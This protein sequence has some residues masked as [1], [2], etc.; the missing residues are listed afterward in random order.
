MKI[1]TY[2]INLKTRT[3]RKVHIINEFAERSEF[4]INMVEACEHK[5]GAIGL[6][7]TIRQIVQKADD[8][9]EEY[10]LICE[11]DHQF[12][13]AYSSQLL[14]NCIGEAKEKDAS[15]LA[16]GVHWYQDIVRVSEQLFWAARFTGTQFIIIFKKFFMPILDADFCE[17]DAADLKM[18]DLTN[19]VFFIYPFISVQRDFGYSDATEANNVQGR[20]AEMFRS[21][22]KNIQIMIDVAAFY[23]NKGI[24]SKFEQENYNDVKIPTYVINLQERMERKAHIEKQFAGRDEFAVAIVDACKRNIAAVGLW[25]S[26]RK[27]IKMAVAHDHDVIIIC[28]DDHEFTQFY[29]REILLKNIF[30]SHRQGADYINAGISYFDFAVPIAENRYW[31]NHCLAGQFLIVYGR[32][33]K[34][35]L[36]ASFDDNVIADM[37]LSTLTVNMMFLYPSISIQRDFGYSDVTPLHHN[38]KGWL[39]DMFKKANFRMKQIQKVH[40]KYHY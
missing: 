39:G 8:S 21:C 34:K 12:T 5:C 28:E 36:E 38:N 4:D 22:S 20:M 35:M 23:K 14:F 3:D 13:L 10:V 2:I 26:I 15:L 29:S 1:P 31:M 19:E 40:Q 30:D 32:F 11:D 6:W 25:E 17:S 33:Y 16:G 7:N 24:D 18:S 9:D 27:I 37:L